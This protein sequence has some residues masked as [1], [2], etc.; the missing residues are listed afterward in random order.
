[1]AAAGG[2]GSH[3]TITTEEELAHWKE[4]LSATIAASSAS[5]RKVSDD[6][7]RNRTSHGAFLLQQQRMKGVLEAIHELHV[8]RDALVIGSDEPLKAM[9][10]I[11]KAAPDCFGLAGVHSECDSPAFA[12]TDPLSEAELWHTEQKK[13]EAVF[14]KAPWDI[15]RAMDGLRDRSTELDRATE[16]TMKAHDAKTTAE[17]LQRLSKEDRE[18]FDTEIRTAGALQDK[19]ADACAEARME[20]ETANAQL[21]IAGEHVRFCQ[22]RFAS[23]PIRDVVAVLSADATEP[24]ELDLGAA[25]EGLESRKRGRADEP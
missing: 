22:M 8:L 18:T 12:P 23:C 5:L 7:L 14:R 19:A 15:V 16:A 4:R 2:G 10:G 25:A 11:C 13:A 24:P 1:M 9:K 3:K 20:L 21:K 6:L 17:D